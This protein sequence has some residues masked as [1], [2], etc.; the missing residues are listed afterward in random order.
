VAEHPDDVVTSEAVDASRLFSAYRLQVARQARGLTKSDLS[1]R[2]GISAAALSQF[3]LGQN[4]PSPLTIERLS[5]VLDFAP[6]FFSNSTVLSITQQADDD[7]VDSYGHFRSLRS[8]T[9]TRRRQVLTVTHLLRDVTVFLERHVKL[10]DLQIPHYGADSPEQIAEVAARVRSDLGVDPTGP[11]EDV[12]RLLERRGIVCARYPMD[13]AD[14]SAFSVP[15]E[16]RAFLVLKAQR[17]AK[18]DRDR[19]S[20]CH[21]LGHL[22]MHKSGQSLASKAMERQ[23]DIFASEFLMPAESIRGDLS[24]KVDWP[25]LL[26]LKQRWGVSMAALLYRSKSLGLMPETTYVQAVRTMNVRGWRK[27]EPGTIAAIE[28]PALLHSALA[29]TDLTEADV[30]SAT[31]WPLDMITDLFAVSTDTR[32]SVQL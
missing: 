15:L 16:R 20:S 28:A 9:A 6:S 29:V 19:F 12:V 23:A 7:L 8:V 31:G 21:E 25:R 24:S 22:V 13:A 14:V 27:D 32:P 2:L 3:E 26:Q 30:S 1:K 4:R 11:I 18:R 10:P 17:Q 5:A